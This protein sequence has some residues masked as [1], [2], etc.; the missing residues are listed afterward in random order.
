MRLKIL[1]PKDKK[2][3]GAFV[4][5]TTSTSTTWARG[6]SPMIVGPVDLYN[7]Y[8]SKNVENAWQYAKV[9]PY[10]VDN[11]GNPTQAYF[12]WAE[13]G[14]N[15]AWADR[16][17]SG[18]NAIPLYSYWDGKKLD[19]IDARKEIY[20]PLYSSAVV[21]T[22]AFQTLKTFC[23]KHSN[24][25]LFDIDGYDYESLGMT[26]EDVINNKDRRMGHAFILAMLLEGYLK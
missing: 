8:Q 25:A 5:N 12:D 24:V 17:P 1:G 7:G 18:K 22:Q 11:N 19:Y 23:S 20:I 2:V 10:H 4:I 21:K 15:K 26:F 6:L 9:Y 3:A 14:W 13:K 16:Y